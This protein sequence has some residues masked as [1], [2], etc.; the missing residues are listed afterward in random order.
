MHRIRLA[1]F[2]MGAVTLATAQ[3]AL[4]QAEDKFA[5]PAIDSKLP[6]P[7]ILLAVILLVGIA[8]A[9]FK[10]AKRTPLR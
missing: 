3:L 10:D 2:V 1:S 5:A 6:M 8:V 4:A 7:A 9:V